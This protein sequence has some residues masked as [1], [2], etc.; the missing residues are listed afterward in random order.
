MGRPRKQPVGDILI[1]TDSGMWTSPDGDTYTFIA[2]YTRVRAGHPLAVAMPQ[3][4]TP[5]TVHY[6]V[7]RFYGDDTETRKAGD[8][9]VQ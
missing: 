7:E 4:F 6:D 2:D 8:P 1:A 5:I 3:C 9:V